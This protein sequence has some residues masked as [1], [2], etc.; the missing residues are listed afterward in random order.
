MTWVKSIQSER[1]RRIAMPVVICIAAG[2]AM[3]LWY[4]SE[5]ID[6]QVEVPSTNVQNV[7]GSQQDLYNKSVA[8][9]MPKIQSRIDQPSAPAAEILRKMPGVASVDQPLHPEHKSHRLIHLRDFHFVTREWFA[10]ESR[11]T[12]GKPLT[13]TDVDLRY[14]Q[15]LV[16]VELVQMEQMATFR[17]LIKHHGL[18]RVYIERLTPEQMP[19]FTKRIA[20]LREAEP[21]QDA[22]GKQHKEAQTLVEQLATDGKRAADQH[23]KAKA[24]EKEIAGMLE[25]HR[26]AMLEIGAAGRLLVSGELQEVFPLDD[27]ELLDAAAPVLANGKVTFD[28]AKVA[29]RRDAMIR[30]ALATPRCA[31]I[32]L[33]GSHDLTE[34]V[35]RIVGERCEYI[36]V[37]GHAY[38]EY[39]GEAKM[40]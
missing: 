11:A 12:A 6:S 31:V 2:V 27:A 9:Y 26:F 1:V 32:V 14:Q 20:S 33:G 34:N 10:K 8:D 37:T 28:A 25:E 21:H 15:F 16:Q 17:S 39:S 23:A 3:V 36:R 4:L 19:E 13:D 40:K 30:R 24:L 22:L 18:Q 35:L 7:A 29:A 5:P 38:R